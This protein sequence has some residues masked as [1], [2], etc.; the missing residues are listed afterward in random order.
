M[1]AKQPGTTTNVSSAAETS[2]PGAAA[3]PNMTAAAA[4][5]SALG[6]TTATP[7]TPGKKG[8][9]LIILSSSDHVT[10]EGGKSEPTG[11]FMNELC[12]PLTKMLAD[13]WEVEF[14]NPMGECCSCLARNRPTFTLRQ[15]HTQINS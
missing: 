3:S 7:T 8:K 9:V 14:A 10:L 5:A 12:T 11:F 13:G 15:A 1:E 4:A 6:G 2:I